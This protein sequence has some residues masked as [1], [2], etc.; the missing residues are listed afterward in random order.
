[1]E[2]VPIIPKR[3][4]TE[5][6]FPVRNIEHT[7]IPLKDGT[8]LAARIWLPTAADTTPLPAIMEYIPYRKRDGTRMRD[9]PMHGFISGHGYVVVRVDMRGSGDSDGLLKDEYLLQEQDDAL[10]AIDWISRQP[11][12]DGN[13]GMM[14]KSWGGFNSLQVAARRPPSLKAIITV[15]FTDDRYHDDIHYKGGCL[16]NDNLWWGAIMLAYQ[17]RPQDPAVFGEGW[18]EAWLDRLEH[19]PLWP[20]LWMRHP[21]RDA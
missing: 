19:M 3:I 2:P 9:E 11:W 18:R 8:R 21:V 6:P 4:I 5:F 1:M 12:C 10:E 16:L 20:E 7:W 13:I 15:G 17:V 14:G